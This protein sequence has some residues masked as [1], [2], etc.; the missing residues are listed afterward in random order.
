[1]LNKLLQQQRT[2]INEQ[3][4]K[5]RTTINEQRKKLNFNLKIQFLLNYLQD[6]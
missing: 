1:M 6:N 5:Q 3:R 4:I 2:T